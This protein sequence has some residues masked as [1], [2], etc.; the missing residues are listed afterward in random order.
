MLPFYLKEYV[1]LFKGVRLGR[2]Q[3]VKNAI[4]SSSESICHKIIT[5]N[6]LLDKVV[7]GFDFFRLQGIYTYFKRKRISPS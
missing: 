3:F 7:L 1:L 4:L 5:S 6:C 2:L